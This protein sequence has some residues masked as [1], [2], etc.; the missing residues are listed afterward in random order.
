MANLRFSPGLLSSIRDFGSSLTE[1]PASRANTLT[2]AGVQP[3]SLGGMLARNVGNL[4]GRDMRTSGERLAQAMADV[5][6]GEDRLEKQLMLQLQEALRVNDRVTAAKLANTLEN[7]KTRQAAKA[8]AAAPKAALTESQAFS[9]DAGNEWVR[10]PTFVD[11]EVKYQTVLVSAKDP[12]KRPKNPVGKLTRKLDSGFTPEEEANQ[13]R[14]KAYA[15]SEGTEAAKNMAE[16]E[17]S[18]LTA[19]TEAI[20]QLVSLDQVLDFVNSPDFNSGGIAELVSRGKQFLGVETA[21]VGRFNFETAKILLK[22]LDN[23]KGAI[24]E[25]EREYLRRNL[26]NMSQSKDIN[27]ALLNDARDILD[28]ARSRAAQYTAKQ[29]AGDKWTL[30][31][32]FDFV[33]KEYKDKYEST[34][35]EDT[36]PSTIGVLRTSDAV[37]F[38]DAA[39]SVMDRVMKRKAESEGS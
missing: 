5:P 9:D 19:G 14:Q 38:T 34:R 12:E 27:R 18:I 26:A 37:P 25:G 6:E 33:N 15:A 3:A 4:M 8:R 16:L 2:G 23:F 22:A 7:L 21:D 29:R 32:W 1:A 24:S 13:A 31:S 20:D 17:K 28:R 11:G 30:G 10:T 36:I 35:G 39:Q